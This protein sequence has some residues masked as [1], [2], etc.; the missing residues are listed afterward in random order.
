MITGF[1]AAFLGILL[2]ILIMRVVKRRMHFKVGLGDGGI[3]ELEQAIRAHGNFIEIVP[4]ALILLFIME[5]V[6]TPSIYLHIYGVTLVAARILHA[7]G[8]YQTP[9]RSFGRM[10]GT[11]LSKILIVTASVYLF[12]HYVGQL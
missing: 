2:V 6:G 10:I 9:Y 8:L 1:Y 4:F 5:Y 11:I 7:I 12:I 3:K